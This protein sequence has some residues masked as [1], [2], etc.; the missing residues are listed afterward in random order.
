MQKRKI[1]INY[2]NT[3]ENSLSD[4]TFVIPNEKYKDININYNKKEPN[5]KKEV[6]NS[7][8]NKA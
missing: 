8:K 7:K 5:T 1:E 6:K 2:G 3:D 4:Y